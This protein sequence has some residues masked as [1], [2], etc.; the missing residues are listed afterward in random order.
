MTETR[1]PVDSFTQAVAV[2]MRAIAENGELTVTFGKDLPSVSGNQARLPL[3]S[4]ELPAGEV[5]TLRG[6]GD[7]LALRQR[8]HDTKIT[9]PT[10]RPSRR[11]AACSTPP[12]WPA[13]NRWARSA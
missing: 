13:W 8:Y 9:R 2:A 11:R 7:S 4:R 3:P 1:N 12:R 6:A 5:A 10:C